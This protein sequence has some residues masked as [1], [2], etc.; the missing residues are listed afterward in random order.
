MSHN[1]KWF[2][3]G[4]LRQV[5]IKSGADIAALAE[6]DRKQ[7]IA[8]SMPTTGVRFDLR[9]LELMDTD[10]DLFLIKSFNQSQFSCIFHKN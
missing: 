2:W 1:W 8:L 10:H 3:A 5:S 6:L 4:R 9:M 7:W